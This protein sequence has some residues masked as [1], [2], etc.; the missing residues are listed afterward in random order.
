MQKL[1]LKLQFFGHLMQRAYS[2]EKTLML[3]RLRAEGK[4]G[5]RTGMVGWHSR[6]NEHGFEQTAGDGEGQGSLACCCPWGHKG[7]DMT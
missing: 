6:L 7:L 4:G 3:G 5:D 2:L 1:K